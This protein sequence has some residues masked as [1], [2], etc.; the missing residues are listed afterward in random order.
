MTD[1]KLH[2]MEKTELEG[3]IKTLIKEKD[4]ASSSSSS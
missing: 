2:E 3:Q 4:K 1:L